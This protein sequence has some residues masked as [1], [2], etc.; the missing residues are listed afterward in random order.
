MPENSAPPV[1][2]SMRSLAQIARRRFWLIALCTILVPTSVVAYSLAQDER[3]EATASLLFRDSGPAALLGPTGTSQGTT[4]DRTAA[5]NENLAALGVVAGRTARRLGVSAGEIAG[6]VDVEPVGSSELT[7]VTATD[8]DPDVAARIANTY[9]EEFIALRRGAERADIARAQ[10]VVEARLRAAEKRI[11]MLGRP[12]DTGSAAATATRR[13][14]RSALRRQRDQLL[15]RQGELSSLAGLATGNV[16]L[17]ERASPPSM[18]V[19]PRT[20]RDAVIGVALGIV[21]GVALAL[22]LEMLDRRLREPAEVSELFDLPILGSIPHSRALAQPPGVSGLPAVESQA[23]DMLRASLRYDRD[24]RDLDSILIASAA[25]R[26]GK[27]TVAIN[28]ASVSARAGERVLL[29]EADLRRP[30]MAVRFRVQA[31]P[32]LSEVLRGRVG[33]HEAITEVVIGS[34]VNGATEP[35]TVDLLVAGEM[36]GDVTG[37]IESDRMAAVMEAA[38]SQY[39]LVVIDTPPLSMVPDAIPLMREV[40]GVLLVMRLGRTTRDA[41]SA[42]SDQLSHVGAHTLGAVVNSISR[43]DIYYDAYAV[44]GERRAASPVGDA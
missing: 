14:E 23:F 25:P 43:Q 30:S 34:R 36:R 12:R 28:L 42:V 35:Y 41:V 5:T 16:Q 10:A 22:L 32:G 4:D 18:P 2:M 20:R 19:S 24:D 1:G 29:L 7:R 38:R 39:D 44:A 3:Y 9:A 11:A 17:V 27:T 31:A 40:S 8:V 26:E 33:L 6:N 21:L 13:A 15:D 37:L